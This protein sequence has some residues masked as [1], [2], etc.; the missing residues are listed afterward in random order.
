MKVK[1]YIVKTKSN[2]RFIVRAKNEEAAKQEIQKD[3][4]EEQV[5]KAA[6]I[7]AMLK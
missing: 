6:Q 5:E 4:P 3:L 7:G 2:R 1:T